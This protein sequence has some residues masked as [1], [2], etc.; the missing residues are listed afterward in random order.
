MKH[1]DK[2]IEYTDKKY[3]Q[4]LRKQLI[5]LKLDRARHY[6]EQVKR[7]ERDRKVTL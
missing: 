3:N 4:D 6:V 2:I 1:T 7:L 5:N